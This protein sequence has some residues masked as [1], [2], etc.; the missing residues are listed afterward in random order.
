MINYDKILS[1]ESDSIKILLEKANAL[2][3]LNKFEQAI[4][5]ID[6]VLD[7]D[8]TNLHAQ[9]GKILATQRM[10]VD[11]IQQNS[12]KHNVKLVS[13]IPSPKSDNVESISKLDK[14]LDSIFDEFLISQ[15]SPSS[16]KSFMTDEIVETNKLY[17][18][19]KYSEALLIY[20]TV[21]L[22]DPFNIYALNGKSVTLLSLKQFDESIEVF[23][24]TSIL[25]R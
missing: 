5:T 8:L 7:L 22:N 12:A 1:H 16:T 11:T 15:N 20:D 10:N 6:V 17:E 19:K 13:P 21:L 24:R 2:I 18:E 9:E 23:E 25:S 3:F 4:V 14:S